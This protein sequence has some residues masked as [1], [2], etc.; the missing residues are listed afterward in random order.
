MR[1][2]P[3]YLRDCEMKYI[4]ISTKPFLIYKTTSDKEKLS[5]AVKEFSIWLW[6]C[7]WE[8]AK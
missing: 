5:E 6:N 8:I 3:I 7:A 2:N 4:Q 1:E